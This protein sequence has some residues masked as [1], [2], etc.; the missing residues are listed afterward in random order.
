AQP[1]QD[2][3]DTVLEDAAIDVEPVD[4]VV[5]PTA[6]PVAD[7]GEEEIEFEPVD[8][9]LF[10]ADELDDNAADV[11]RVVSSPARAAEHNI[12]AMRSGLFGQVSEETMQKKA[13]R[14]QRMLEGKLTPKS[15]LGED[16]QEIVAGQGSL[17]D[18]DTPPAKVSTG[19]K[20]GR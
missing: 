4:S 13:K 12:E 1:E 18:L 5:E 9:D 20:Q 16:D 15:R 8:E 3:D 7:V 17:F 19:R 14:Y 11:E 6:T 2:F 10:R